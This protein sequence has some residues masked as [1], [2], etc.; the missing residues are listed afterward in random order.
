MRIEYIASR[1]MEVS[2]WSGGKTTQ[3]AIY[4]EGSQYRLRNFIWR[5]STA[6]VALTESDFTLLPDYARLIAAIDGSMELYGGNGEHLHT[7]AG[8]AVYAFDG[9]EH[10]HCVGRADD[11]NLMLRKGC[12]EGSLLVAGHTNA[13][14]RQR[15]M[16]GETLLIYAARGEIN[17]LI[18]G[19][20]ESFTRQLEEGDAMLIEDAAGFDAT[21][22][23]ADFKAAAFIITPQQSE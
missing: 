14:F 13:P 10:I 17:V 16:K 18:G 4:P 15:L 21:L 19:A 5:A 7:V 20:D 22:D 6:S 11:L 8:D 12:A 9:G 23:G 3:I 1:S 2:D